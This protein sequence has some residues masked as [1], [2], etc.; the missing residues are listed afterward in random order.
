[1][2]GNFEIAGETLIHSPSKP[3]MLETSCLSALKD[4]LKNSNAEWTSQ[5]QR[6]AVLAVMEHKHDVLA[7][8]KTGGGKSMLAIIPAIL[9][10]CEGV[11]VVLP[12]KSLVTD[13]SRKLKAMQVPFQIYDSGKS[14]TLQSDINIILVSADR[15]TFHGFHGF[16]ERLNMT[17]P[18]RRLVFDEAHLALLADDYRK[19]LRRMDEIRCL[20]MQLVLLSGTVPPTSVSELH[21]RFGLEEDTTLQIRESS[22]RPELEYILEAGFTPTKILQRVVQIV[23]EQRRGWGD[24]DRGLVYVTYLDDGS[25]LSGMVSHAGQIIYWLPNSMHSRLGGHST[26]GTKTQTMVNV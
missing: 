14:G 4:V 7:M 9:R 1:M 17:L 15:A 11:V 13:W 3:C 5:A 12:L 16:L 22:N 20:P 6:M 2:D 19:S 23:Q 21:D 18:I 8:L 10:P 25:A 24:N 26:M